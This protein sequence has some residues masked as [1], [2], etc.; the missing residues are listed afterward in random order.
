MTMMECTDEMLA[1][2]SELVDLKEKEV[3]DFPTDLKV[4]MQ[5]SV[6]REEATKRHDELW[7]NADANG[8]GLLNEDEFVQFTRN[9]YADMLE[10]SGWNPPTLRGSVQ[11]ALEGYVRRRG[12][13]HS[14][15]RMAAAGRRH[16]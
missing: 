9:E 13:I 14:P 5:T 3:A 10:R 16:L 7:K 8:D 12:Q 1:H 15:S 2:F 11:E 4:K 6:T